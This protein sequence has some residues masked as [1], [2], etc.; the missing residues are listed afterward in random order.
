MLQG[1]PNGDKRESQEVEEQQEKARS[2][3]HLL[4]PETHKLSLEE[5]REEGGDHKSSRVRDIDVEKLSQSHSARE[6]EAERQE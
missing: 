6:R 2:C 3:E 4:Q 5:A 1:K